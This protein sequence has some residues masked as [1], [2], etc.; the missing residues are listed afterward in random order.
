MR[1]PPVSTPRPPSTSNSASILSESLV[2]LHAA[3]FGLL[4]GNIGGVRQ[5]L[6]SFARHVTVSSRKGPTWITRAHVETWLHE[7][8]TWLDEHS[9]T[10]DALETSFSSPVKD[11]SVSA[12]DTLE[13]KNAALE[14]VLQRLVAYGVLV[15][16]PLRSPPETGVNGHPTAS[17]VAGLA[18]APDYGVVHFMQNESECSLNTLLR[19]PESLRRSARYPARTLALETER[20]L[21]ALLQVALPVEDYA[22]YGLR[23]EAVFADP[24]FPEWLTLASLLAWCRR[25][26]DSLADDGQKLAFYCNIFNGMVIQAVIQELKLRGTAKSSRFPDAMELLRRTHFVLCGE[27]MTLEDLRDQVI[28]FG[29]RQS[30]GKDQ[31]RFA[32]LL[33][34][35]CEPRVHFVLHWGARSSPLPR[36]VHLSRWECDLD[37]A[38]TS[39]LLNPRQVFIPLQA[40]SSIQLSRLF[41]WFG[42]D[43]AADCRRVRAEGHTQLATLRWIHAHLA[44]DTT[45]ERALSERLA[46]LE[47]ASADSETEQ[48]ADRSTRCF[49]CRRIVTLPKPRMIQYMDFDSRIAIAASENAQS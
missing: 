39:F 14:R 44:E 49:P 41:E 43:F 48:E 21:D 20:V 2:R 4:F 15:A 28:R 33:V 6:P 12:T 38:T 40:K 10:R 19:L 17:G 16:S 11:A 27:L 18:D 22:D 34:S 9:A 46:R 24:C 37:A 23:Y 25:P 26:D 35:V 30:L 42:E 32:P 45:A 36:C 3:V 7:E 1:T 29:C 47:G 5:S 13:D 31:E 8:T